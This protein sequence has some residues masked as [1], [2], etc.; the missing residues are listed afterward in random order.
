MTVTITDDVARLLRDALD[1]YLADGDWLCY[2]PCEGPNT[3]GTNE[4]HVCRALARQ[5]IAAAEALDDDELAE[6]WR[7]E[8]RIWTSKDASPLE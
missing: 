7:A 2:H 6:E 1:S 8:L 5:A 3:D 4:C